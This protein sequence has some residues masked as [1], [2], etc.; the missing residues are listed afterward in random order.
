MIPM[1]GRKLFIIGYVNYIDG[2]NVA[3]CKVTS[4]KPRIPNDRL[5]DNLEIQSVCNAMTNRWNKYGWPTATA[6]PHDNKFNREFGLK[7]ARKKV[8][9]KV[10]NDI[11]KFLVYRI[12]MVLDDIDPSARMLI[13]V[14]NVQNR[15]N[16]SIYNMNLI[17][18][19]KDPIMVHEEE[20]KA[21]LKD[22]ISHIREQISHIS[23]QIGLSINLINDRAITVGDL[24]KDK[25]NTNSLGIKDGKT[26]SVITEIVDKTEYK[27]GDDNGS[28]T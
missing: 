14:R 24:L 5:L 3:H 20:R 27:D 9:R 21:N 22:A 6:K 11:D 16:G 15:L 13:Y 8:F 23:E 12:R 2:N 25:Y 10:F 17:A 26:P 28:G 4:I 18:D 1:S 7:L 19:G